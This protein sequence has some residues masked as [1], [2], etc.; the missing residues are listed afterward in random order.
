MSPPKRPEPPAVAAR[1]LNIIAAILTGF[2]DEAVPRS[3]QPAHRVRR[4]DAISPQSRYI[5]VACALQRPSC[6]HSYG[7]PARWPWPNVRYSP[8]CTS[9][10][11]AFS[12]PPAS[13]GRIG[14]AV[15]NVQSRTHPPAAISPSPASPDRLF[16][17]GGT[18][19]SRCRRVTS[20]IPCAPS[21]LPADLPLTGKNH[22]RKVVP[23]EGIEPPTNG[24]QNRC[25]T[26]ELTRRPYQVGV[27]FRCSATCG[28]PYL[29]TATQS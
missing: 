16:A 15:A 4:S 12:T 25:S 9:T 27:A 3:C 5:S 10:T 26:A 28:E 24:L 1:A 22:S 11:T 8:S 29:E 19:R 17:Y 23:G 7:S 21:A 13:A 2:S 6:S 18:G 20:C 14:V